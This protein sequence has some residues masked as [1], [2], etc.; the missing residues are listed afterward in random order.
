[1]SASFILH[2]A[3]AGTELKDRSRISGNYVKDRFDFYAAIHESRKQS[4]ETVLGK[5][6][7]L[8][9]PASTE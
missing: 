2:R 5:T 3:A 4:W 9:G 8:L 1:M 6:P 7:G